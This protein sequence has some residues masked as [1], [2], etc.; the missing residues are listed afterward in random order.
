[1]TIT[2][3][4]NFE[5]GPGDEVGTDAILICCD[6]TMTATAFDEYGSRTHTCGNCDIRADVDKRGLLSDIRD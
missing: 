3:S 4:Y 6:E 1:M 5:V 2:T